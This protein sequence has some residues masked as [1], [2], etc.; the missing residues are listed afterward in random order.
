LNCFVIERDWHTALVDTGGG[1]MA[2]SCG[3]LMENLR[4]AGYTP[5]AIDTVLITHLHPDHVGGAADA[6]GQAAFPNAILQ[7][8][9]ADI[10]FWVH[11]DMRERVPEPARVFFDMARAGVAAYAQAGRLKPFTGGEVFP[12]VQA[13]PLPGHTP[14]HSGYELVGDDET[15][16]IWGD[17][18][19][20]PEVQ[21]RHP[22]ATLG[23]FDVDQA[24]AAAT[25]AA[26]LKRAVEEKLLVA[27]MHL[28]FPAFSHVVAHETGYGLLP[29]MWQP[30]L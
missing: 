26:V 22:E 14:G 23:P 2:P 13:V 9:Q 17:V 8:H 16:L 6:A 4:A 25:R 1:G 29:E 30:A 12:G 27:G 18:F 11:S 10:D 19:H 7:V 24:Q 15:L 5:E 21:T 20:V 3:K 28:H